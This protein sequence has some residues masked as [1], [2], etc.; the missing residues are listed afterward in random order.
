MY[1][2]CIVHKLFIYLFSEEGKG[3]VPGGGGGG[4]RRRK[5]ALRWGGRAM[6][7]VQIFIFPGINNF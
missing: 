6:Y 5:K 4:G 7:L 2:D 1:Y 3:H